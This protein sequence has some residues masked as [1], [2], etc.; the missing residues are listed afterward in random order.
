[1]SSSDRESPADDSRNQSARQAAV[2][3]AEKLP[4]SPTGIV[5]FTSRGRVVVIGG[6]PA[7]WFAARLENPL[8]AEVL[9]TEGEVEAGVPTTP[10]AGRSLAISGHLGAFE[11]ALGE[12][13]RHN[14]QLL[15]SDMIVD[16][17]DSPLVERDLPPPGYWHFGTEPQDLDAAQ[18]VVEGMVGTFEKPRFFDYDPDICAHN[19]S[20]Q[21]G[22]NRCIEACPAEAIV[23]VG[24]RVE[25]DPNLCQGGG[26]CATV[27]PSGAMQYAYPP[28]IDTAERIRTLLHEYDRHGGHDPTLLFVADEDA[29][30]VP[31]L[32]AS[33]LLVTVEELASAG[34]ELWLA[35][36]AWGARR[37]ILADGGSVP[38]R[39]RHALDE[40]FR[41]ARGLLAGLGYRPE[42]LQLTGLEDIIARCEAVDGL[43]PAAHF[44]A[45]GQ[46]RQLVAL[47]MEHFRAHAPL[48]RDRLPLEQGAPYGGVRVNAE[49]CT[50]CMACTS[51]CPAGAISAGDDTPKLVFHETRCVQCGI[52]RNAC[53][54]SAIALE[55]GYLLDPE[56]RRQGATLYEDPPFCCVSCGKPFATRRVIDAILGKLDGHAMFGSERAKRRLQMCEDCRVVDAVQDADAMQSGLTIDNIFDPKRG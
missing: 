39:S 27:C 49:R 11:I 25:V 42:A 54:E 35:A 33:V 17:G 22:C 30:G 19:R 21:A 16:L 53:P 51:V 2:S 8:H 10:Q 31:T 7:Q 29:V 23:S 50:L 32:P 3:A 20:G 12:R 14:Y 15:Q 55:A 34:H 5:H 6:E 36:L 48:K 37:V 45:K 47:A 38:P 28:T 46:K 40:Q 44:A 18:L 13:G 26:T 1:M 52:C 4:V 24:E 56:L 43:P 41:L 9:L